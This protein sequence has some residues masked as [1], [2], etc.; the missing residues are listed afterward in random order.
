LD[1]VTDYDYDV[2]HSAIA[3]LS[4]ERGAATTPWVRFAD[5]AKSSML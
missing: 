4:R 1:D 2:H 5:A 3:T